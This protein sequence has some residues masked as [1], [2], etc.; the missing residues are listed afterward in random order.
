MVQLLERL[1]QQVDASRQA[2]EESV[3]NLERRFTNYIQDSTDHSTDST[4]HAQRETQERPR[5]K[6]SEAAAASMRMMYNT[7]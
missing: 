6:I 5:S 1:T 7:L 4:G 2:Q 3:A